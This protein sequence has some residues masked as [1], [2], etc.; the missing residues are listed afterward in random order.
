MRLAGIKSVKAGDKLA[1]P[2]CT[3]SGKVV[4]NSG[5]VLNDNY[6]DKLRN[7]RIYKVYIDDGRFDD[8]EVIQPIDLKTR[9][10]AIQVLSMTQ[11]AIQKGKTVDEYLIKDAAKNI[12]DYVRD[13]KDKGVSILSTSAVDEYIIEHSI[14]VAIL[15]AFLGNKM[16]YNFNQLCDLVAGALIHDLGRDNS[17]EENAEHTQKGFDVMRKSRGLSLHSSI[18]CYEHH[19][20]FDGTG[21]PRKLKG[22]AISEFSRVVRVADYYDYILQGYDNKDISLMPHQ[23]YENMLAVAG[24]IVDPEIVEVFRDTIVFY[25]NGCS[26]VLSNGLTGIVIRQNIGSP[27][28]P[29]V[30]VYNDTAVLGEIDLLKSL[31]LFIKDVLVM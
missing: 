16:S 19:E 21:Y 5:I 9:N 18:V 10:L 1:L 22:K 4:L 11:E 15:S 12:V 3:S 29:V 27:Q 30:R 8:I 28:R 7:L 6:I 13:Y 14:N 2:V 24:K 26:V 31:T 23:A 25:P 20:N 17:K